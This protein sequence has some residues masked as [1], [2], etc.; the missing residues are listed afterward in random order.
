MFI[1]LAEHLRCPAN[2]ATNSYC[3]LVP[4]TMVGRFV[5]RGTVACPECRAEYPIRGGV[6][7]FGIPPFEAAAGPTVPT[8]DV[9]Q[10]LLG[11]GGPGGFVGFLGAAGSRAGDLAAHQDGV[12]MVVVNGPI[13]QREADAS[14]LTAAREIPLKTNV[15]R[16]VVVGDDYA[17]DAW[18]ADASR[19]LLPGQ[20]MVV[21]AEVA[22]EE[23]MEVIAT[24]GGLTVGRKRPPR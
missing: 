17:I 2:H 10:A 15:V 12:H 1:E 18:L 7:H 9:L 20:R 3:I 22:L 8:G 19:V 4:D 24:G 6:V 11:L 13:A 14:H 5:D 23:S 21:L 16:G